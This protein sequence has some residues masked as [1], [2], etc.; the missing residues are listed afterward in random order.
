MMIP[1]EN[2]LVRMYIQIKETEEG[3]G[4]VSQSLLCFLQGGLLTR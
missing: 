2:K 1:R 4:T 3:G